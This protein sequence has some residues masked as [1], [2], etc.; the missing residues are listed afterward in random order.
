LMKT[1]LKILAK[2][3]GVALL[4]CALMVTMLPLIPAST[5]S[6]LNFARQTRTQSSTTGMEQAGDVSLTS[7]TMKYQDVSWL[8]LLLTPT[9]TYQT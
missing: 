3:S 7:I 8:P 2:V 1:K 5:A 6:Q 4:V 9:P